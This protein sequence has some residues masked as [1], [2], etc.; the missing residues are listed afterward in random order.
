MDLTL[1]LSEAPLLKPVPGR[2]DR[3]YFGCDDDPDRYDDHTNSDQ[4]R[5]QH[6]SDVLDRHNCHC[7][8][9]FLS[10]YTETAL[11]LE[12]AY[13]R[14]ACCWPHAVFQELIPTAG[15]FQI[16]GNLLSWHLFEIP[17]PLFVIG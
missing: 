10:N 2:A 15:V 8:D 7:C 6:P 11:H 13:N 3:L 16:P 9:C 1:A 12:A 5:Y 17:H 4:G 14:I